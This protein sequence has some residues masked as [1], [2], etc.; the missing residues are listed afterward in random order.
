MHVLERPIL[1]LAYIKAIPDQVKSRVRLFAD[2]TAI[3]LASSSEGV[4]YSA[5]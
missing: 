2:D 5:K 4:N 3:Y 1:F